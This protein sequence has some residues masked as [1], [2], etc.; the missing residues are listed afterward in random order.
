MTDRFV[1][2]LLLA[3]LFLFAL[4]TISAQVKDP[5]PPQPVPY[6]P[7]I[8]APVDKPYAGPI[9]LEV[10]LTNLTDRVVHVHERI[11]LER[12]AREM[13]LLYPQ[14]IPGTHSPTGPISRV[15]GVITQ[16]DGHRVQWV[17]DQVNVYAFHVPLVAG[18]K[19]LEL[20]FDYLS[21]NKSAEG[22]IEISDAIADLAWNE[23]AMYPAGYFMRGILVDATLKLPEGWKYATALETSSEQGST[24]TFK[25]TTLNE[26]FDSPLYAGSHF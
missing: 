7:A 23:V 19:S 2:L 11:P 3:A 24:L 13:V 8:A 14:W 22:R 25:Q 6:G 1:R 20:D 18:A 5:P 17:R 26:L 16:V 15:A 4:P 9:A 10:D 21:P 12:G